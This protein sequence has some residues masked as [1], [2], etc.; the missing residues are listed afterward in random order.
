MYVTTDVTLVAAEATGFLALQ[1]HKSTHHNVSGCLSRWRKMPSESGI[2]QLLDHTQQRLAC[3]ESNKSAW[4]PHVDPSLG[5]YR[6]FL[7]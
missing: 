2:S 4:N 3:P 6:G 1:A 5:M 7:E